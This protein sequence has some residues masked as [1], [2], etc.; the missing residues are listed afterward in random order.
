MSRTSVTILACTLVACF[1]VQAVSAQSV[2]PPGGTRLVGPDDLASFEQGPKPGGRIDLV[3][4]AGPGFSKALRFTVERR[5][6]PWDVESGFAL[7]RKFAKGEVLLLRAWVRKVSSQDE[8]TQAF[9]G[10]MVAMRVRPWAAPIDRTASVLGGWQEYLL[11]GVCERD[12]SPDELFIKLPCG[13]VP[14][15]VEVGG[16]ELLTY[17]AGYDVSKLPITRATYEGRALDAPW[18][19]EAEARIEAIR[20]APLQV[21]VIDAKGQPIPGAKVEVEML[22]HAFEFGCAI[23]ALEIVDRTEPKYEAM[24]KG[25]LGLFNA[26]TFY[27]DLKWPAW[28]GEYGP[29][30]NPENAIQ[31]LKWFREH[32]IAAR[33]HVLVWPSWRNLPKFLTP[34]QG[35]KP[36]IAAI[37]RLALSHIDR[38]ASATEGLVNEWDVLNEPR[39]NHDLM[40]LGGQGLMV[41]WFKRARER[42]PNVRLTL[43]EFGIL[44]N[45]SDGPNHS[46]LEATARYLIEH[47][48][49]LDVIGL[50]GHFG[51]TVPPPTRILQVLDRFAKLGKPIRITEYDVKTDDPLLA[52]DFSRDALIAFFSHPSVIGF[53]TW[54]TANALNPDGSLNA[55]GREWEAL[56]KKAWW[57]RLAGATDAAGAYE[58]RGFLGRYRVRAEHGGKSRTVEFTLRK[59]SPPLVV[60]VQ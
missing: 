52:T 24:R 36:D 37:Q 7:R 42:L 56:I 25:F 45:L 3:D 35:Q 34:P 46:H 11:P 16:I 54:G 10:L 47:G 30:H 1:A 60:T 13:T 43:N 50:Q 14:Q 26:G 21:S 44:T 5:G 38:V 4:S 49:P 23:R 57:T 29:N 17:G 12:F 20:K 41:E 33:G 59:G 9:A 19:K 27:N 53:Q 55:V 51:G 58:G 8:S 15:V 31:A 2:L 48:A 28:I 22:R 32:D 6:Q 39:D 18:R 40:D